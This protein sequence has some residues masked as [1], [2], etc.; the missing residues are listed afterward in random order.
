MVAGREMP[1]KGYAQG[2]SDFA[3]SAPRGRHGKRKPSAAAEN[4]YWCSVYGHHE[5]LWINLMQQ[6]AAHSTRKKRWGSKCRKLHVAPTSVEPQKP[7][8]CISNCQDT[9]TTCEKWTILVAS[10]SPIILAPMGNWFPLPLGVVW[11]NKDKL[12]SSISRRRI[13]EEFRNLS[14]HR[15]Q[16]WALLQRGDTL[17]ESQIRYPKT[18]GGGEQS[19]V[20]QM[21][22]ARCKNTLYM[23]S[24]NYSS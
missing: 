21:A 18:E 4:T 14:S 9:T 13:T 6:R 19:S 10:E 16:S 23:S 22:D 17:K 5:K 12:T 11:P 1:I 8:P 15:L 7:S 3:A 20:K 2:K 24:K